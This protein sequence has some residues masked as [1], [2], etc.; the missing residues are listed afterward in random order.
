LPFSERESELERE[1]VKE[2]GEKE[3]GGER[4]RHMQIRKT[5][6]R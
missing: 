3:E 1:R 2:K 5:R 6:Y 4:E